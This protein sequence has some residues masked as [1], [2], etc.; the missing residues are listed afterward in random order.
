MDA[1][2]QL[3][4]GAI[5]G[6]ARAV[7]D[8]LSRGAELEVRDSQGESSLMLAASAGSSG[9]LQRLIAQGADVHARG[10]DEGTALHRAA[11]A[12]SL[13]C[14]S[15]LV[16]CDCELSE[17]DKHGRTPLDWALLKGYRVIAAMLQEQGAQQGSVSGYR[18]FDEA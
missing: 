18:H 11:R 14:V 10:F 9:V 6:D 7:E 5:A 15:T 13:I 8:A 3:M 2:V 1:N 16:A 17:P 4:L 12:G